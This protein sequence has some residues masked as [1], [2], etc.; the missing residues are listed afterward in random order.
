M[1]HI[2]FI[3]HGETDWNKK[4]LTQGSRND[5][6][7]N[8]TGIEQA[9]FTGKYLNEYRQK[10]QPF[11]LVL[12]SPMKRT[13][14]TALEICKQIKYNPEHIIYLEELI[15]T[16]GG[17]ITNGKSEETNRADKFFDYFFKSVERIEALKD[18]IAIHQAYQTEITTDKSIGKYQ[19]ETPAQLVARSERVLAYIEQAKATNILVI[20]HNDT[21]INGLIKSIFSIDSMP[22]NKKFGVN[23]HITYLTYH[24]KKYYMVMPPNTLHFKIYNKSYQ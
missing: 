1:K 15:E 7:L 3:R 24:K 16:D 17:L 23:C 14:Q 6:P 10:A 12:C 8:A 21:I 22:I 9:H 5:I 20:S 11:D 19:M 2:Y 18:P 4:K 13:K